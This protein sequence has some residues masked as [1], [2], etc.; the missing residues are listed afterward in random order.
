MAEDDWQCMQCGSYQYGA[1]PWS[2]YLQ[3]DAAEADRPPRRRRNREKDDQ[4]KESSKG[5]IRV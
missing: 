5:I 1:L 3:Q 2:Q 4:K